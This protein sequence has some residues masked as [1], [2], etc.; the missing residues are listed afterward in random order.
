[1]QYFLLLLFCLCLPLSAA[2]SLV[3]PD[4]PADKV[5]V[6]KA[7]RRLLLLKK[8]EIIRVYKIALG[9]HPIGH[10]VQEGDGRTPEGKYVISGRNPKS[11]YHLSLRISYPNAQD[12]AYAAKLGVS[13]GGDI[14]I[15]GLPNMI[16]KVKAAKLLRKDWTAGCLAVT[17]EE[18]EEIWKLVPDGTEIELKA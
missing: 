12:K 9:P 10:K 2:A 6:E 5:I 13:P 15:H 7:K 14:M 17:D 4:G 1:M 18:I 11:A 8:G 3:S 16:S